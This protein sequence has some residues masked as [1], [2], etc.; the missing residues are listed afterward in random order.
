MELKFKKQMKLIEKEVILKSVDLDDDFDDFEVDIGDFESNER[1]MAIS[2]RCIRCNLCVEN[3]PVGAISDSTYSKRAKIL[4]NCVKC[5]IC[6]QTCPV[7]A[8][9]I[10]E[11]EAVINN[12]ADDIEDQTL[13]YAFKQVTIPHRIIRLNDIEMDRSKCIGC[14][15]CVKYCPTKAN[16]LKTKEYIEEAE[17]QV[18]DNFEKGQLY[19]FINKKL[20]VGCGSCSN[21]CAQGVYNIDN[22]IGPLV[23]TKN[24][25]I[26]D[27]KCVSCFLCED[28]CPTA[29]IVLN[30]ENI[31]ELDA[32][33]CIRCNTCSDRCPVGALELVDVDL[34]SDL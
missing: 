16:K 8:I 25:L 7:S 14:G 15:H 21:I 30:S 9:Y 32:D 26:H 10:F 19:P 33:K 4:D 23:Q 22:Y 3:C 6:V 28:N 13:D 5:E 34:N 27:D 29:A 17:C 2:P 20:C 24:L 11:S 31:P 12:E 18:Y 1:F